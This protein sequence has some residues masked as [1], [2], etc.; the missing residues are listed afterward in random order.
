MT[1]APSSRRR[2]EAALPNSAAKPRR[3]RRYLAVAAITLLLSLAAWAFDAAFYPYHAPMPGATSGNHGENG[4]WL[5]DDWYFGR[6]NDAD[7][8]RLARDL[9]ARQTRYAYFHVRYIGKS[10]NLRYRFPA[11][12]RHLNA[13]L[14]RENPIIRRIAWVYIG[15]TRGG[16]SL[17]DLSDADLRRRIVSEAQF[18]V[19]ECG[20]DGVQWDYEICPDA[21]TGL[22][23]LL[24]ETRAALPP[25]AILS[26]ATPLYEPA[27]IPLTGHGWSDGYF[28][29]IAPLC[30]QICVM[31]YDSGMPT[32]RLFADTVSEQ[33]THVC[34]AAA[35]TAPHCRILIGVPTYRTGGWSH[36]PRAENLET[37]LRGVRA[38]VARLTPAE[39]KAFASIAPFAD[40][41][42]T[43]ED[44]A[45]YRRDWLDKIDTG[46]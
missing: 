10:G 26:V 4:L 12:A 38:G 14:R 18:L 37:A 44:W 34:R 28:T 24:R 46:F 11:Q 41:T 22:P 32:P 5:G 19:A 20:F 31:A 6:R 7:I 21:D 16:G 25:G 2:T 1:Y 35:R 9:S 23:A 13:L 45:T 42:T 3:N 29:Q 43:E 17:P 39:R 30:D 40:Y 8:R 33:V 36:N 27:P 15:N